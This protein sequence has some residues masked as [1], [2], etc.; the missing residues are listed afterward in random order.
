MEDSGELF[1]MEEGDNC[2]EWGFCVQLEQEERCPENVSEPTSPKTGIK[3]SVKQTVTRALSTSDSDTSIAAHNFPRIKSNSSFQELERAIGAT[4]AMSIPEVDKVADFSEHVKVINHINGVITQKASLKKNLQQHLPIMRQ[5]FETESQKRERKEE[6]PM[7]SDLLPFLEENDSRALIIF[8]SRDVIAFDI[9]SACQMFGSLYYFRS[10]FHSCGVTLLAYFDLRSAVDAKE[11]LVARLGRL[12]NATVYSSVMLQPSISCHECSLRI[13][14]VPNSKSE[15]YVQ[16]VFTDYGPLRSIQRRFN[17]TGVKGTL[18][19]NPASDLTCDYTAEFYNIQDAKLAQ[20][21]MNSSSQN[22]LGA[23]VVFVP[24]EKRLER[25]KSALLGVLSSWRIRMAERENASDVGGTEGNQRDVKPEKLPIPSSDFDGIRYEE[26]SVGSASSSILE[27]RTPPPR[28]GTVSPAPQLESRPDNNPQSKPSMLGSESSS[29]NTLG[30]STSHPKRTAYQHHQQ[31]MY[32]MQHHH[33]H[34]IPSTDGGPPQPVFPYHVSPLAYHSHGFSSSHIPSNDPM[35]MHMM[36]IHGLMPPS[37]PLQ[38]THMY[39]GVPVPHYQI[40]HPPANMN[41]Y[42]AGGNPISSDF[43]PQVMARQHYYQNSSRRQHNRKNMNAQNGQVRPPHHNGGHSK[44]NMCNSTTQHTMA[45]ESYQALTPQQVMNE[46]E[47]RTTL[48]I[49]NIPNKYTQKMLLEEINQSF[50]GQYDFFYLPIDFKNKCNVG[51][52]FINFVEPKD[53]ARFFEE[54]NDQR[55]RNFNSEKVCA[56]SYARI[57]GKAAM[58][59]R[60]QNSSLLQKDDSYKPLL[61]VS[62]GDRKGQ[63]EPFIPGQFSA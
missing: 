36:A 42:N 21:E 17:D 47:T 35:N 12:A 16:K 46:T 33:P 4:L 26:S 45:D 40:P 3:I 7:R 2:G 58:I 53:V 52:C 41:I 60:Y 63:P 20:A 59:S 15:A 37:H 62:G 29:S 51:Y 11:K 48:M 56:L 31:Q 28:V 8:H 44:R 23:E 27:T 32:Q 55:W 18:T 30:Y 5:R 50:E 43:G 57:Q 13:H 38:P 19:E 25:L 22:V 14:R 49:R 24:L 1:H 10:D 54:F 6:Y 61:F 9:K 34:Y 39:E